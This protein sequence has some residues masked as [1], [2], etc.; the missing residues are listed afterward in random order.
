MRRFVA[1]SM[2]VMLVSGA[3][4]M[5]PGIAIAVPPPDHPATTAS[6][7][8]G[9]V[10]DDLPNP[11]EDKRRALREQAVAAV[12]N[13]EVTPEVINGSKVAKIS[14][15]E[16]AGTAANGRRATP[17][18]TND[19]YVELER[20]STDRIFVILAQFGDERNP[21]YPDQDTD[22]K[23]P[24]PAVFDGP[25]RNSIPVPNRAVDNLTVWQPDY[26]RAHYQQT[27]FGTGPGVESLKTYYERQSSGRYSVDG[28]VTDWVKVRYNEARYGRSDGYPCGGNVCANT[29][30]LVED[31]AN[32]W[33][34]DQRAAGRSDAD[35]KAELQTF[36][37]WDR[38]DYDGDGDFN[39]PDGYI[40]HFQ[41]VHA[42]GDQADGDPSQGED[43]IWSHRWRTFLNLDGHAGPAG[44]PDGGNQ[45][46]NTG[47]WIADYTI[48]PE[49]GGRSVFFH[50]YGHD[51]GL[52]D[53]YDTA[54]GPGTGN[55][56][57]YWTLMAQSRLGGRNEPFIGDRA[58]DIGA[59]N[60]LQLGWLD[61]EVAVAGQTRTVNL[62]PEEYN[63][64][65]AQ[66][67]VVVLPKKQIVTELGAPYDG[68]RQWWS[69]AGDNLDN[70]MARQVTLPAGSTTLSFQARWNIEDCGPAKCDYAYV[71]VDDGTGW[72]AIAGSIT[73]L[74]PNEGNGIDGV[75]RRWV[76]AT[77]DLSAYAGKTINIRARYVTD[78][79]AQGTDP[80]AISGIFIDAITVTNNGQTIFSDGAET[81]PNGW[82][83]TGF[84]SVEA[85]STAAYD[86][87]Y[88]AGYRSYV[89]YDKYLKT[90]P[91]N[92]G[93]PDKPDFVE[94]YAYQTGLL[95]SYWDTSQSDN[96]VSTHPGQGRNLYIDA[97]P[98]TIYNL[99]GTTPWRT[100][101]QIYD[102]PFGKRKADSFT[103]HIDGKASY[104]RGQNGQPVFDD[105]KDWFDPNQL[106]HGVKVANAGVKIAVLSEN[107]TSAR[108]RLTPVS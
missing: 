83:L 103:L 3:G 71:E 14:T 8:Q 85:S 63:S 62:G 41:I 10:I 81:P 72:A 50:E 57:E 32:Q 19:Q 59:W 77:F 97:H 104:I 60:K 90:G 25:L 84:S 99:N 4:L 9:A 80:K 46:G 68:A 88:I 17:A 54:G 21:N 106:D 55:A 87:Y 58:G 34:A 78:G 44:N 16:E 108:V 64:A 89:S 2:A 33:V 93:F 65:K 66:A 30:N 70:S 13:G 51:L 37:K 61:Y 45:I 75:T 96:N 105:T 56:N 92:F 67:M 52:P 38:Y 24:G 74:D 23:I 76:P 22:P 6:T 43:A 82:T 95:I 42:G 94:H 36:D 1:G 100:R 39:E 79:A 5:F 12:I 26:S 48:Q 73:S 27:Y 107:G 69:G 49:N 15:T 35:I 86:N 7:E 28:E 40:D 91:Y 31:A 98:Q 11:D 47:I 53:D 102:A 20:A 101:I 18:K 29:W